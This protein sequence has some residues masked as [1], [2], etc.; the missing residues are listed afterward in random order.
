MSVLVKLIGAGIGL[1]SEA[2]KANKSP[3]NSE[4]N[5]NATSQPQDIPYKTPPQYAEV[6]NDQARELISNGQAVPVDFKEAEKVRQHGLNSAFEEDDEEIWAL[7]EAAS[8][9]DADLENESSATDDVLR[10]FPST[11]PTAPKRL[12]CPV[13][14]PQ[15]RPKDKQRGFVRAYAPVLADCG[16][17][18]Q[19]FLSFLKAFHQGSQADPWLNVV[20]AAAKIAGVVPSVTAMAVSMAV[21]VLVGATMEIQRRTK[22]NTFLDKMNEELFKP[23]GLYCLIMTFKPESSQIYGPVNLL[24][25]INTASS[26]GWSKKLRVFSGKTHGEMQMPES[27]P[28]IFPALDSIV[29]DNTEEGFKKQIK[30]KKSG[31]FVADYFDRRAQAEYATENPGSSLKV[32]SKF[33]SRYADPNSAANSGS[34]ISLVTGGAIDTRK[35]SNFFELRRNM[36]SRNQESDGGKRQGLEGFLGGIGRGRGRGGLPGNGALP[37]G[38]GRGRPK[39]GHPLKKILRKDVLYMMIVNLPTDEEMQAGVQAVANQDGL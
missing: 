37:L 1:A 12:P 27:A 25:S 39:C 31:K 16:I 36:S 7:D 23:R 6:T 35:A 38:L 10:N 26:S 30:M 4:S 22:S 9:D 24:Q 21:Q 15:R 33:N 29:Y 5:H 13:I 20:N 18:Q 8:P 2:Y 32:N 34:L 17:D 19:A 3:A 28:L 11:N 14:I